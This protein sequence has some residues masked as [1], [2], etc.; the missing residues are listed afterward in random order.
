MFEPLPGN[1][2]GR[3]AVSPPGYDND[4]FEL[5]NEE[6]QTLLDAAGGPTQRR[7]KKSPFLD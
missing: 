7:P 3:T 6:L 1:P 4:P 2:E 5:S